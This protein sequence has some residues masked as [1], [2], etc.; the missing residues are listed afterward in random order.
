ML[1]AALLL[2]LG[3]A[4]ADTPL[5]GLPPEVRARY[6]AAEGAWERGDLA[7]AEAAFVEV[8]QLAPTF[9]RAWRRRC[10]VVLAA[11]RPDEAV[12]YCRKARELSDSFEN[13]VAL[14]ISLLEVEGQE[15]A[16]P[17]LQ[18]AV[19]ANPDYLPA[20]VGLCTWAHGQHD[21]ATLSQCATALQRLSPNTPG[22]LYYMALDLTAQGRL[23][24]AADA[25]QLARSEGLTDELVRDAAL[26]VTSKAR[27]E[28]PTSARE[29]VE[30]RTTTWSLTDLLPIGLGAAL[31]L[32]VGILA[33]GRDEDGPEGPP[34]T[35]PDKPV[36]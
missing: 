32:A 9:D 34:P 31:V 20:Q 8:N 18:A 7:A 14:A 33:F 21:N 30:E 36:A 35:Q 6:E 12:G 22:T 29:K 25:L 23:Q 16:G 19:A 11:A 26:G 24:E 10:G 2:L 1:A 15:E 28:K 3:A 27:R 4:H 17:L 5:E 13:Q